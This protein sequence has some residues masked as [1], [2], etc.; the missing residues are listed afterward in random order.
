[1]DRCISDLQRV[2]DFQKG[3]EVVFFDS[4]EHEWMLVAMTFTFIALG[5]WKIECRLEY[6]R[7]HKIVSIYFE[8]AVFH[9]RSL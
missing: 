4:M 3:F 7:L 2:N 9:L 8:Q 6:I 5:L 1:V